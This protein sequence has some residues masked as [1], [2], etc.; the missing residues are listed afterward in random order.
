MT[1]PTT[2]DLLKYADL[3]MAAEAFIRDPRT[4][5]LA[6]TPE[7]LIKALKAGNGHAS[8]FTDTQAK[9]FADPA[10]G[11]T[12]LD[13]RANTATG[14]SGTLFK[15]NKTGEL[16]MSMRSTE[17][18]DDAARDSEATNTM[19]IRPYGW[20]FGQIDDMKKWY[21]ELNA[22]STTLQGKSFA[23][24][25]YSLGGHLATA[26]NLLMN[27]AGQANRVTSTYTFNGAGVGELLNGSTLTDTITAFNMMRR[28]DGTQDRIDMVVTF[29]GADVSATYLV[30]ACA[31]SIRARR[32]FFNKT[33]HNLHLQTVR[34]TGQLSKGRTV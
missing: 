27:D 15:N 16:V 14:F 8:K 21:D 4:Q 33:R 32:R 28:E 25:G 18:L 6:S 34:P 20:A 2:A 3:Q 22:D 17:F 30:A 9:A 23:V 1:T 24:T 13:Q 26:F 31:C 10:D 11:W 29:N 12:V 19:E 5:I 7:D